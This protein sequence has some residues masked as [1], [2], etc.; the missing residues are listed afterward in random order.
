MLYSCLS[1]SI[2]ALFLF[3]PNY[4]LNFPYWVLV[5][6]TVS[7]TFPVTFRSLNYNT[8][9]TILKKNHGDGHIVVTQ[10][11]RG[12]IFLYIFLIFSGT[13]F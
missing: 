8:S 2:S 10:C 11:N 5:E 6:V 13:A 12:N 4:I 9:S 7:N 1:M 3:R